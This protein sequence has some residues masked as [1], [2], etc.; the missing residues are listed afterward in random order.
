MARIDLADLP[1]ALAEHV[2]PRARLTFPPQ[3]KTSD[4]AFADDNGRLVVVKRCAHRTYLDWLRREHAVLRAL[5]GSGLPVPSFIAYAEVEP[6]GQPVGWLLMSRLSGWPFLS[7]AIEAPPTW[8]PAM[9]RRLGELLRRL[10][11]TS[12]P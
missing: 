5:A 6:S 4:V 12:V 8:R 7:A 10:H 3:G 9:F 1:P 2:S 11:T